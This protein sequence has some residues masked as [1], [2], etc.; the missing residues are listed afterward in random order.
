MVL[1][2]Q[3]LIACNMVFL[4]LSIT[5]ALDL[6]I[7]SVASIL[8]FACYRFKRTISIDSIACTDG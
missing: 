2:Y 4:V 8:S 6:A 5:R 1:V 7:Y 3:R